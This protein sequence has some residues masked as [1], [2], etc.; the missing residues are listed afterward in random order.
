MRLQGMLE[1]RQMMLEYLSLAMPIESVYDRR[2][3]G[4]ANCYQQV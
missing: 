1:G 4:S 2:Q 3:I